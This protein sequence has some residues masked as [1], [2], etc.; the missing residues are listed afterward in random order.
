MPRGV[1]EG[2]NCKISSGT[3]FPEN[4][5][6]LSIFRYIR[7]ADVTGHMVVSISIMEEDS[8]E[9]PGEHCNLGKFNWKK[10]YKSIKGCSGDYHHR[11]E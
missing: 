9:R 10:F 2:G 11:A 6:K 5:I 1:D 8:S 7:L 3:E 4:R